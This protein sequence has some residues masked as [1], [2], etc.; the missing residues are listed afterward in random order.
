MGQ[1]ES[2]DLRIVGEQKMDPATQQREA[3]LYAKAS[4]LAE[5]NP[6]S[7]AYG[8]GSDLPGMGAMSKAGQQYLTDS[9]L[10]RGEYAKNLGF[11]DYT[12]P[13]GAALAA[14][15][16]IAASQEAAA[17]AAAE[18]RAREA[19]ERRRIEGEFGSGP[20]DEFSKKAHTTPM[21][22]RWGS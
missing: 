21:V 2:G 14:D 4:R 1:S 17:A 15:A 22:A 7:S 18:A 11:T 8:V 9:I 3:N 19:A 16:T 13:E 20:G 5:T 10:G 12:R 6:Y